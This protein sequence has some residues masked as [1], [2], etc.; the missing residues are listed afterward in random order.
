M[1]ILE[2]QEKFES[3]VN[4]RDEK[5]N[6]LEKEINSATLDFEAKIIELTDNW[7][8]KEQDYN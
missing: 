7:E 8:E 5:I 1:L 6:S 3:I 2:F 4:I